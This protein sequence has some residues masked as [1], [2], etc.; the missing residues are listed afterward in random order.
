MQ[1]WM[2][3]YLLSKMRVQIAHPHSKAKTPAITQHR[4]PFDIKGIQHG[5]D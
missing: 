1:L 3:Y 2:D 5:T 4:L